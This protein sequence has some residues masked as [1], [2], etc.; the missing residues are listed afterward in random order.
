MPGAHTVDNRPGFS[1]YNDGGVARA[2]SPSGATSQLEI[3]YHSHSI[4]YSI[5][6]KTIIFFISSIV[7]M[8]VLLY[9]EELQLLVST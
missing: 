2:V 8:V 9:P 7:L 6:H 4:Q 1:V 3:H 5:S